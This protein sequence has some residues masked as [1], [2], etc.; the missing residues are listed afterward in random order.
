MSQ[1]YRR[2]TRWSPKVWSGTL[3]VLMALSL[4]A[5]LGFAAKGSA[6]LP[7]GQLRATKT[8]SEAEKHLPNADL[9]AFPPLDLSQCPRDERGERIVAIVDGTTITEKRLMAELAFARAQQVFTQFPVARTKQE[10]LGLLGALSA[11]VFDQLVDRILLKKYASQRGVTVTEAEIDISLEKTNRDLPPGEK[12]QDIAVR[13]GL[14]INDMR[15]LARAQILGARLE[16]TFADEVREPT[17]QELLEF[18]SKYVG[19]ADQGEEIRAYHIFFAANDQAT[20]QAIEQAERMATEVLKMLR[21]GAD[22][23]ELALRYSQDHKTATRCGDLGYIIRGKMPPSFD[24]VAFKLEAGQI[25]DLVRTPKGF[26]IIY[27]R[28]KHRGCLRATYFRHKQRELYL[29]W[30]QQLKQS[31]KIEKFF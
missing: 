9:T 31:V 20:T 27:V 12:V 23:C 28:E 24:A 5:P 15:D 10:E 19:P 16:D 14:S 2:K 4:P 1:E 8:P 18:A 13:Y 7:Q 3:V 30:Y 29:R 22:F 6:L 11:P 25:S 17:E 21:Q 26:H